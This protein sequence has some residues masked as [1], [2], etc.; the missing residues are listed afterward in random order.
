MDA[1]AKETNWFQRSVSTAKQPPEAPSKI[2]WQAFRE[3]AS[4]IPLASHGKRPLKT[5]KMT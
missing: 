5:L 1:K 3:G 2:P 4:Q